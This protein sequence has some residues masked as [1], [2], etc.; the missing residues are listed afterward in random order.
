MRSTI[1]RSSVVLAILNFTGINSNKAKS[2]M[3]SRA[4]MDAFEERIDAWMQA[5]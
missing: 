1:S 5:K 4:K 2:M 3:K